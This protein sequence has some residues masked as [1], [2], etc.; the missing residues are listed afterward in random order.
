[1]KYSDMTMERKKKAT[2]VLDYGIRKRRKQA[3]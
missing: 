3:E 1:M 2:E